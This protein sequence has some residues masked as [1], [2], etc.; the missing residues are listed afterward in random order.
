MINEHDRVVLTAP[1]PDE[2]LV[3]GDVGTVIHIYADGKAYEVEF[4]ALDGKTKTVATLEATQVRPV[5]SRDMTHAR[6]I[7][8]A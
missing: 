3:P 5:T 2:G 6:E 1:I 7:H 4:V 8:T